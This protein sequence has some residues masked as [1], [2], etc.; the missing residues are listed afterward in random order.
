MRIFTCNDVTP[1]FVELQLASF[2]KYLQED[3]EFIVFNC[4]QAITKT[5]EKSKQ[6]TE[7]CRSLGVEVREIP[8]DDELEISWLQ[9]AG[10]PYQLFGRDGRFVRGIGGDTFNYMLQWVWKRVLSKEQGPFCFLHSDVFLMEPIRFSDYLQEYSM[11]AVLSRKARKEPLL[12]SGKIVDA[13]SSYDSTTEHEDLVYLWEPFLLVD[14]LKLP[15]PEKMSWW[16]SIV[17]GVWTDTG[18]RTHYYLKAHPE[19]KIFEIGQS[20]CLDDPNVD[21]HPARYSFFHLGEKRVFHYYSGSKW[22]T[23]LDKGGCWNFSRDKSDEYHAKKL[24]WTR[25][26]IGL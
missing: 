2:R 16:P 26:L 8:R 18:G 19:I 6:V 10:P 3:F 25:K 14:I 7:V 15:E 5:P 1:E 13:E 17:E 12:R 4:S 24:A 11:A 23:D 9:L 21:F 20:G 22:C